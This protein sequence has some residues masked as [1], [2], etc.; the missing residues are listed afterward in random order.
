[1]ERLRERCAHNRREVTRECEIRI[2]WI[3]LSPLS[4]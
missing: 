3:K 4:P 1:L 2:R